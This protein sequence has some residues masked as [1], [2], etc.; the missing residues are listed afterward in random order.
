MLALLAPSIVA[1]RV[2][3]IHRGKRRIL[4]VTVLNSPIARVFPLPLSRLAAAHA[5]GGHMPKLTVNHHDFLPNRQRRTFADV[6]NDSE[7]PFDSVHDLSICGGQQRPM[8]DSETHQEQIPLD[9]RPHGT[10][11][12]RQ[13]VAAKS[14]ILHSVRAI[15]SGGSGMAWISG[16]CGY[17]KMYWSRL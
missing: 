17:R 16:T 13:A 7:Q 2:M 3:V 12:P 11:R 9:E 10:R 5:P 14:S 8:P 6:V 1:T 4:D 15:V